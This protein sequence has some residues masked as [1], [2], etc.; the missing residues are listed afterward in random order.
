MG[1]GANCWCLER[2]NESGEVKVVDE[3]G[4]MVVKEYQWV[5]LR[6]LRHK[7]VLY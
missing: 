2:E 5:K 7:L 4:F 6:G 1:G 3:A